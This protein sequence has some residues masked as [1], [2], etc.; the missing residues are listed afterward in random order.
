MLGQA[1]DPILSTAI[2]STLS[3]WIEALINDSVDAGVEGQRNDSLAQIRIGMACLA[4]DPRV[5]QLVA[6]EMVGAEQNVGIPTSS[7]AWNW[8][9]ASRGRWIVDCWC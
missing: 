3:E 5:S 8:T 7:R 2:M 6:V 1:Q 4:E 9:G